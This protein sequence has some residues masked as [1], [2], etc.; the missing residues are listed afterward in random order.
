[1]SRKGTDAA[2]AMGVY[3]FSVTTID[4]GEQ[5]LAPFRDQVMLIVNVASQCGFTPQYTGLEALHRKLHERGFSVLGFPCNQFGQQEPAGEDEIRHFCSQNYDV[6]FPM[7]AKIEV[8]GPR[9][10][11]LYQY[12][13]RQQP[14]I[15]GSEAIKWN[16][17]KFLVDRHGQVRKRYGSVDKPDSIEPDVAALLG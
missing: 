13:K 3:D 4:G 1:M 5:T 17:T 6:T 9:T 2:P 10:H 14:G 15:L 11:P 7:F 12:L 8:N 16:F